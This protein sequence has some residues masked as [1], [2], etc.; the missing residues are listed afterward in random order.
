MMKK[1]IISFI[2]LTVLSGVSQAE[3]CL[4]DM[5]SVV[6]CGPERNTI[7]V[8]TDTTWKRG[9]D[10]QASPLQQQIQQDIISQQIVA[11]KIPMDPTAADKYVET[12]KK[13]NNFKDSDLVEL[14]E[15]VGRT[16]TEGIGLLNNQYTYELFVHHKFKSQLVPTE[17]DIFS[18]NKEHP[19]V[20]DAWCQIQIAFI[21]FD[22]DNKD[23][24]KQNIDAVVG[25]ASV[26]DFSIVWSEP[27]T[28]KEGDIADDK[29]FVFDMTIGQVKTIEVDGRFE[30]YKLLE[31]QEM[32]QKSLEECRAAIIDQLNRDKFAN[33]L[34]NY[35][36]EVRKFIDVIN[37]D[38]AIQIQG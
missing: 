32:H 31:K 22:A 9:L 38:E 13:Q 14:F 8:D 4:L 15:G 30:V 33:M 35:N 36:N 26:P 23:A 1:N 20:V 34:T 2:V 5:G 10:G 25:G 6:V 29:H 18:Y 3:L 28:I 37:L 11:D 27:I 17:D 19:Q 24:L 7:I 12:L 16:F 21:D